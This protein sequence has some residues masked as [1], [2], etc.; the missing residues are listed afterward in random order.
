MTG[1]NETT[2]AGLEAL[3]EQLRQTWCAGN[4]A[5]IAKALAPSTLAL[6]E[7]HPVSPGAKVLDVA[8][9]AGQ[10][11]I[12]AARAGGRIVMTNCTPE[13]FVGECFAAAYRNDKKGRS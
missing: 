4:Y 10:I 1:S 9:G 3:K 8:C 2:A 6:L 7:R 5:N 13:G 12:P 11:A